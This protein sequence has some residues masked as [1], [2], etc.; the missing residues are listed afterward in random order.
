MSK[1]D[2]IQHKMDALSESL[3]MSIELTILGNIDFEKIGMKTKTLTAKER[4][5]E[6]SR[7]DIRIN[8]KKK[9][10]DLGGRCRYTQLILTIYIRL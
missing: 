7:K 6:A 1:A 4:L 8:G 3:S 9:A 2:Q 5:A 10:R